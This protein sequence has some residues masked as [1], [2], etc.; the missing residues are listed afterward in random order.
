MTPG[1][2]ILRDAVA[3]FR[4]AALCGRQYIIEDGHTETVD[5]EVQQAWKDVYGEV[6][7]DIKK[8]NNYLIQADA[9]KAGPRE[10]TK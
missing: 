1:E 2:K 8:G 10:Q 3:A 7:E 6:E 4:S 9:V 5:P